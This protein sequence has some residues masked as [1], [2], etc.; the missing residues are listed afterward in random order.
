MN[1]F[2]EMYKNRDDEYWLF[3]QKLVNENKISLDFMLK[4]YM[5]FIQ[6]RD[7]PQLL[8]YYELFKMVSH[9]PGSFAEVGVFVGNGLFTWSKL[10]DTFC[11][12]NRGKKVFGFDNYL[13]YKQNLEVCDIEAVEYIHQVVGNFQFD[14]SI[15]DKL[16]EFTNLDQ[17]IAGVERV[18]LYND[19]LKQGFDKFKKENIGVRFCLVVIDVNLFEPTKFALNS[20]YD[21]L[22]PQGI[23]AL[24][25][26]GVRPWEG[27]SLAV[28]E[29]IREKNI[30]EISSF[31][32]S[33]YPS[34][35]F[36]K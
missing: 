7:L 14:S 19:D 23:I 30:H 17:V 31:N 33:N 15:V 22:V 21:L 13:G 8:A 16:V 3:V 32:F 35:Y 5:A 9:L 20:F 25:G 2:T 6:R 29:F 24:R 1:N 11:P 34:I 4:N 36:R 18:K 12:T 10:L 26:Y 27:E 28:D